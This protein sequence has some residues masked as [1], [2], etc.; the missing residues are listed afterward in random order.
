MTPMRRAV[1]ARFMAMAIMPAPPAA[2]PARPTRV[3][4]SHGETATSAVPATTKAAL[5]H[6]AARVPRRRTK[7]AISGVATASVSANTVTSHDAV[8][9]VMPRERLMSPRIR[10]AALLAAATGVASNASQRTGTR[11]VGSFTEAGVR[12]V[13]GPVVMD[14]TLPVPVDSGMEGRRDG[15]GLPGLSGGDGLEFQR[16]RE[17]NGRQGA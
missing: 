12:A 3:S 8:A 10:T 7:V 6:S 9:L 4:G 17:A 15:A 2:C 1:P 5:V 11:R 14:M 16:E 13:A